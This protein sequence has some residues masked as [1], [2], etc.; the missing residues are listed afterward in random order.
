M[1]PRALGQQLRRRTLGKEV[2]FGEAARGTVEELRHQG[3]V[4]VGDERGRLFDAVLPIV[5]TVEVL[6]RQEAEVGDRHHYAEDHR[7]GWGEVC[8]DRLDVDEQ[9]AALHLLDQRDPQDA[10]HHQAQD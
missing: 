7:D 1:A 10:D 6:D 5:L 9:L 4:I 3:E 2:F 8:R